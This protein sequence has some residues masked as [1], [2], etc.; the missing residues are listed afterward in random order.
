MPRI[1]SQGFCA[2]APWTGWEL[3]SHWQWG[4]E[5]LTRTEHIGLTRDMCETLKEVTGAVRGRRGVTQA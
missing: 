2:R 5:L 4:R 3:V 1:S